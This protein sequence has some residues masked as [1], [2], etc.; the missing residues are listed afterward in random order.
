[1]TALAVVL[2]PAVFV[3]HVVNELLARFGQITMLIGRTCALVIRRPL[4]LRV[5]IY[6]LLE[7]GAASLPLALTMS[8][9]A[10]M[11]LAFQF[12]HGLERFGA[13]LFIGQTTVTALFRELGPILTALVVG[14]RIGAGITA[15]LGGMAVSDQ[16]D[17]VRALGADP[18]R[19]LVV[20]RVIAVVIA[21]PLL[22]ICGD[23]VGA[24]GGMI[25]AGLQYGVSPSLYLRGVLDFVT[26]SDFVTGIVKAFIFGIIIGGVACNFG[27]R[28]R[29]GTEGVGQATTKSVVWSALL[30]LF[31]DLLLTKILLSS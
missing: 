21:L 10:G 12:G 24:V 6:Q 2:R 26:V 1:M 31:A 7:V 11:V 22:T 5:I 16:I 3:G 25:V 14:G 4:R 13:K 23:L 19:R 20:P 15:E 18:V 29:G 9:F 27:T 8:A 17:A 28:A 30:V